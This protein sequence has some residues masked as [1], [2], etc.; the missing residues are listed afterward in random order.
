MR[1]IRDLG[2]LEDD[3]QRTGVEITVAIKPATTAE[4]EKSFIRAF[5]SPRKTGLAIRGG[6]GSLLL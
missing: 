6:R 5:M 4:S 3:H 2:R 1:Q